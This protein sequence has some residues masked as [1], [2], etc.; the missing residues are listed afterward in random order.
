[1]WQP[2]GVVVAS[3]I[4]YGTAAKWRCDPELPACSAVGS[5][6][7]CCTVS[8]NMGWRY[9]V[10]VLGLMTLT[11]FFLRFFVFRF[12]ES[13]KFLLSKGREAEAI[14]V[15]HKIAKFN[16]APPPTLTVEHFQ[17]IDEM[18]SNASRIDQPATAKSVVKNFFYS[19][20]HM[21]RL[22]T[23]KLQALIF[24]LLAIAYMVSSC[25]ASSSGTVT[26]HRTG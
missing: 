19:F 25:N 12:Y 26:D 6:E 1:L 2:V 15:L 20:K 14:E 7:A 10:I 3:G 5:G 17:A 13:P 22:F 18:E 8:S 9:E 24:G 16:K 11:V 21:K 23:N 4:A